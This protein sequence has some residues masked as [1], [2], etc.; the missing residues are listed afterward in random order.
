MTV[1]PL[2]TAFLL[3]SINIIDW[4]LPLI[5]IPFYFVVAFLM[6]AGSVVVEMDFCCDSPPHSV[7]RSPK[8]IS[9][10]RG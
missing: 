3:D 5:R 2:S 10:P 9:K 8:D 4:K 1:G 7:P 6:F